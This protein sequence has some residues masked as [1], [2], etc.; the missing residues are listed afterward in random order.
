MQWNKRLRKKSG[1]LRKSLRTWQ[2]PKE[3][4]EE[5]GLKDGDRL[6]LWLEI[7]EERSNAE[8][9]LTSGGEYSLSKE[10]ASKIKREFERSD[11]DEI[12]F[13]LSAMDTLQS[14]ERRFQ[15]KVEKASRE[16]AA[17]IEEQLAKAPLLPT[18]RQAIVAVYDRSPHVVVAVLRRANGRCERCQEVA[19]FN[20]KSDGTPYLEV[21]HETPLSQGGHDSIENAI[22]LC[23][24]CHR[25]VH[26]G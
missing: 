16:S 17:A 9:L 3:E 10:I 22:A 26:L 8:V 14:E 20:R 6:N 2:I 24:N 18:K 21:H 13:G 23:P 11:P 15:E 25:E 1:E 7:G 4:R 19:P 5:L 12:T